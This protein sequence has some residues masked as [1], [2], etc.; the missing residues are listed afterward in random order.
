MDH[1][2]TVMPLPG[3]SLGVIPLGVER[4][5]WPLEAF[6]LHDDRE[7]AVETLT[8]EVT[9]KQPREIAD[10]QRAFGELAKMAVHGD[11]ARALI[12]SART[13]LG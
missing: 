2:L 3:V 12:A 5:I 7:V 11:A 6:Y 9:V 4:I 8:A 1:L 10:Y 13:A